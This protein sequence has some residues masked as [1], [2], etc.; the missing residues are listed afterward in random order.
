MDNDKIKVISTVSS[1]P[2]S[3]TPINAVNQVNN[4][5]NSI[6]AEIFVRLDRLETYEKGN[7]VNISN[8]PV[9]P[10]SCNNNIVCGVSP[11]YSIGQTSLPF[12]TPRPNTVNAGGSASTSTTAGLTA[13]TAGLTAIGGQTAGA[14]G[15]TACTG[16][17]T[18]YTN[19]MTIIHNQPLSIVVTPNSVTN[20]CAGTPAM[21]IS[22]YKTTV[23]DLIMI[24]QGKDETVCQYTNRFRN[25]K[26]HCLDLS[27]SDSDIIDL[28]FRGLRSCIREQILGYEYCSISHVAVRACMVEYQMRKE[29]EQYISCQSNLHFIERDLINLTDGD[30]PHAEFVWPLKTK[31]YS[32]SSLKPVPKGRQEELKFTFDVSKCD[33]IFDE[34]YRLGYI[35][36]SHVLPQLEESKKHAYCKFHNCYSHAINDCNVFRRKIQSAINEG[37]L[38]FHDMQ[39][40]KIP[41]LVN[42]MSLQQPKVLIRP[43]QA[44][45]TKGKNVVVGDERPTLQGKTLTHEVIC[46]TSPDGRKT[47]KITVKPSGHGGGAKVGRNVRVSAV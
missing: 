6:L 34:L 17:Q 7:S 26:D 44:E 29:K 42:T 39:V 16:V 33:R 10:S 14:A 12:Q 40:E 23:Q 3:S 13:T 37:R 36:I 20:D 8:M 35:K 15:L 2:Q 45:S 18:N 11:N 30:D 5:R 9:T 41:L 38:A 22:T 28:H 43:H 27:I 19:A 47:L 32:C 21:T 1:S 31:T 4:N 46:E 24:R 25:I